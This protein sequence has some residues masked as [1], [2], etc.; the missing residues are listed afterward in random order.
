[1]TY[2]EKMKS[3]M[4]ARNSAEARHYPEI[5]RAISKYYEGDFDFLDLMERLEKIKKQLKEEFIALEE[6]LK[7]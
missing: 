1:M 7:A 2:S 5:R 6:I 4:N 3:Y